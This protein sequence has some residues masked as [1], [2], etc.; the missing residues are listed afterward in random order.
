MIVLVG[1]PLEVCL[2]SKLADKSGAFRARA[3]LPQPEAE[4]T[5]LVPVDDADKEFISAV[6]AEVCT[7]NTTVMKSAFAYAGAAGI[8][9]GWMSNR[10]A[11][12]YAV[13]RSDRR[14]PA[15]QVLAGKDLYR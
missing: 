1:L 11:G 7:G 8:P 5:V 4:R 12:E 10:P 3:A 15:H 6:L 14:T 2:I 13:C 9:I